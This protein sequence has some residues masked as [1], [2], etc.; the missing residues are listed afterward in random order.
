MKD[1]RRMLFV[2]TG[3]GWRLE[4]G[5]VTCRIGITGTARD[6]GLVHSSSLT[7]PEMKSLLLAAPQFKGPHATGPGP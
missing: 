3:R 1:G 2:F 4:V 5:M 6:L 7:W